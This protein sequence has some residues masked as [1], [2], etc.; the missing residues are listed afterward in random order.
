MP[1]QDAIQ[2]MQV[3]WFALDPTTKAMF[4][5]LYTHDSAGVMTVVSGGEV[6]LREGTLGSLLDVDD[7]FGVYNNIP[8]VQVSDGV[9][10]FDPATPDATSRSLCRGRRPIPARSIAWPSPMSFK[11]SICRTRWCSSS[12]STD[13]CW[14]PEDQHK[15]RCRR[16]AYLWVDTSST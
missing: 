10:T 13:R 1:E 16:P 7:S 14:S 15:A 11:S 8:T 3:W 5:Q 12:R 9:V 6:A 4:E 2:R